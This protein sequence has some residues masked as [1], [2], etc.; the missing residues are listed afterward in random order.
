MSIRM[1][2]DGNDDHAIALK[3]GELEAALENAETYRWNVR[4]DPDLDERLA[5]EAVRQMQLRRY[6]MT[7]GPV[8]TVTISRKR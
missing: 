2:F 4:E 3:I 8:G 7:E 5:K 1:H 6:P